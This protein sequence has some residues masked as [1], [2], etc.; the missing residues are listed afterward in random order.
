MLVKMCTTREDTAIHR[1]TP[2]ASLMG[3]HGRWRR[4]APYD[5]SICVLHD[6]N[7]ED[8][9]S[10]TYHL[11]ATIVHHNAPAPLELRDAAPPS[12]PSP[13]GPAGALFTGSLRWAHC[14]NYP[15]YPVPKITPSYPLSASGLG[16]SYR[17]ITAR[18]STGYN[19]QVKSRQGIRCNGFRPVVCCY[20]LICDLT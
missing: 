8:S 10:D 2:S 13:R 14:Q 16:N 15:N 11:S 19:C 4:S 17:Y 7:H 12:A 1:Q 5:N 18:R 3:C 20:V 9:V 6:R